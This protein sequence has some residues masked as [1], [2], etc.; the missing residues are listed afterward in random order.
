M[1]LVCATAACGGEK[2]GGPDH[3]TV[4]LLPVTDV[5]P[6]Y[7]GMDKGFFKKHNVIVTV[8]TASDDR[9][10]VDEVLQSG[11]DIGFGATPTIL[12]AVANGERVEMVAPASTT[13]KVKR[14]GGR[15]LSAAVMVPKASPIHTGADL[16]GKTVAVDRRRGLAEVSLDGALAKEGGAKPRYRVVSPARMRRALASGQVDAAWMPTPYKTIADRSRRFRPVVF[17]LYETRPGQIDNG[18][19]VY[20]QWAID[21]EEA[22]ERFNL[23]LRQSMEYASSHEDEL[24]DTLETYTGLPDQVA[25]AVPMGG[26]KPDCP[27]FVTSSQLLEGLMLEHAGLPRAPSIPKFV[28]NGFCRSRQ[29]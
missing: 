20:R 2:S 13:P 23:G 10:T 19:F 17:P 4:R 7:L 9:E 24:R 25:A 16:D 3:V 14:A 6:L 8:E 27:E 15:S 26:W 22:L 21:N 11:A 18:Y 28:R 29:E 1:T 12:S 5:A